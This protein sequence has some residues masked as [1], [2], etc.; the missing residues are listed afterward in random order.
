MVKRVGTSGN[1]TAGL[2]THL[3]PVHPKSAACRK[4]PMPVKKFTAPD[5]SAFSVHTC[6]QAARAAVTWVQPQQDPYPAETPTE[7][8]EGGS[9]WWAEAR[10]TLK[11]S[12]ALMKLL[13]RRTWALEGSLSSIQPTANIL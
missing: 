4:P 7:G 3:N 2:C 1:C 10:L 12:V 5:P 9:W 11:G 8:E 6:R 13:L